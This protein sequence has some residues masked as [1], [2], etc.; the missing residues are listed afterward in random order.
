MKKTT[1]Y[2]SLLVAA[3]LII[4]VILLPVNTL[5]EEDF[6]ANNQ[7]SVQEPILNEENIKN[8]LAENFISS[9]D[10]SDNDFL[11]G[12]VIVTL[13]QDPASAYR[14]TP[15]SFGDEALLQ[16]DSIFDGIDI[17]N[18]ELISPAS[19]E[20]L[21]MAMNF[22]PVDEAGDILLIELSEQSE[23]AVLNAIAI[24]QDNE[25]VLW[26]EP[27]YIKELYDT[28][29][30]DEFYGE[31]WGLDRIN[32]P[33]AWDTF[34]GS[35]D[36]VVGVIDSGIDYTHPDLMNN[37][38]INKDEIPGNGIDDDQDG[39]IDDVYG[40]NFYENHNNPADIGYHG[41]HV[42]GIIA[43]EGNNEIGIT[44]V[45]WNTKIAALNAG[46]DRNH[47]DSAAVIKALRYATFHKFDI[48]NASFG[49]AK[50]SSSEK[51]AIERFPGLL[52]AAAGND[53]TDNDVAPH[54][55][56]S[57]DCDNIIAVANMS[58]NGLLSQS[59]N[60]GIESVDIAA[61]GTDIYSTVP[62]SYNYASGTS[63]ASPCVAGAA[64]LLKGYNPS[65]SAL[66]LKEM[67]LSN[68]YTSWA[69]DKVSSNGRLDLSNLLISVNGTGNDGII[70]PGR[71]AWWTSSIE[72]N[73]YD[74]LDE[75][76][77]YFQQCYFNIDSIYV[78]CKN[79]TYTVPAK[80]F[81]YDVINGVYDYEKN[82]EYELCVKV[83]YDGAA[84]YYID[85]GHRQ[86]EAG[87]DNKNTA[88]FND[89]AL[90]HVADIYS[91]QNGQLFSHS[92]KLIVPDYTWWNHSLT[93]DP[94]N[95]PNSQLNID[96]I[97]VC[98]DNKYYTV[99]AD[100]ITVRPAVSNAAFSQEQ[101]YSLGVRI[102]K[103]GVAEYG[104]FQP[105][106]DRESKKPLYDEN[107][108]TIPIFDFKYGADYELIIT[109]I[110][111]K[112]DIYYPNDGII[113]PGKDS[114]WSTSINWEPYDLDEECYYPNCN[115][116]LESINVN[117][118]KETY[119]VPGKTFAFREVFG[120]YDYDKN[121]EY[122]LNV[123][124]NYDGAAQYQL[125]NNT[126][127]Y[128]G[129]T[130]ITY[131]D[132]Y[133][134]IHI[135]RVQ[136]DNNG[137]L[138]FRDFPNISIYTNGQYIKQLAIPVINNTSFKIKD[139]A[140]DRETAIALT[141]NGEVYTWGDGSFYD[142]GQGKFK[143]NEYK[144]V[145]VNG[146]PKI[147][148][149]AKGKHHVLALDINGEIWGWGNNSS[150]EIYSAYNW[151]VYVPTKIPGINNV[152]DIAAGTGFSAAV[153]NDGT[154]WTWGNN[155]DGKLGD[156]G[157][158][159]TNNPAQVIGIN[160]VSK[161][162][163]GEKFMAA[164]SDDTVYTWGDNS[165]GQLGDGTNNSRNIPTAIEGSYKDI[166]AG[167][168]H[169]LAVSTSSILYTWGYN[170]VGQLGLGDKVTRNIPTSTGKTATVI[171]AGY[172]HSFYTDGENTYGFGSNSKGQLGIGEANTAINPTLIPGLKN[173]VKI[174]GGFDFT[175]A[176]DQ[177]SN[178][179]VFGNNDIG[180]L[181][182]YK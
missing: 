80:T 150:G 72:W 34:T 140:V 59:S 117:C 8:D 44:G 51:T 128:N 179:W 153:K 145:K 181:G 75:S 4:S 71:D 141:D 55:P 126:D 81:L 52:V 143:I 74:E 166:V 37:I 39:Y 121:S 135:G 99:P 146:L 177:D 19:E 137:Q 159:T 83:Y 66:E 119:T 125:D 175:I 151:K 130:A 129:N 152:K 138:F 2:L 182:L 131:Y 70:N 77:P 43:A 160:N 38:W 33:K 41:T 132:T 101:S 46:C 115:F 6:S 157:E 139:I 69:Y 14:V 110:W 31:L 107:G 32:A 12:K 127:N 56:S 97:Q 156:H 79:K 133:A 112:N 60:Y 163:C 13:K 144:P 26:A 50:Y 95:K 100:T 92:A 167:N 93:Y 178:M 106:F 154:L 29:P 120:K 158:N 63:M 9:D 67:I 89:Y 90:I 161:I 111:F 24:L 48:I 176:K 170:S 61:P 36:V 40:W 23:Q 65:L 91:D 17:S 86:L 105:W 103:N 136:S 88:Y 109:N 42:A 169:M 164:L 155:T 172:N 102:N 68:V 165:H 82:S 15:Y 11:P 64:A 85:P 20:I 96:S 113:Y 134:I 123:K 148:K 104:V 22:E 147:I 98:A 173:I 35:S 27:D 84:E 45:A 168:S 142:L 122:Y 58:D 1:K 114:W 78:I 57:Y 87:Q 49:S 171:G 47:V 7:P 21:P 10:N 28:I 118:K 94:D 174:D 76:G 124:V 30:D 54:Y 62:G 5:A 73:K 25:N 53:G 18:V 3:T 149:I 180:Q 108:I 162:T 116:T 16:N